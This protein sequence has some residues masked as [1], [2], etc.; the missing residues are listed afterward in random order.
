[1]GCCLG[2]SCCLLIVLVLSFTRYTF[3]VGFVGCL[4]F[5]CVFM[6]TCLLL[7]PSF[8]SGLVFV[9]SCCWL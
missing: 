3:A 8:G 9:V 2:L 6:V 5:G 7:L 4:M 1:M